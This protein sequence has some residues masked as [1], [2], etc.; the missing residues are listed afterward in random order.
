MDLKTKTL[1]ISNNMGYSLD[2]KIVV[3]G[4][5]GF[6]GTA[7]VGRLISM[8][9]TNIVSVSRNEGA[10][11]ALKEKFPSVTIQIGDIAD[12]WVVKKAMDGA[13]Q[14]YVL[15][16]LKHVGIAEKDVR[17]CVSTNIDGTMNILNESLITKP[18]FVVFV[19][20]DKAAQ[21][22]G[23]Y[24]AS[25][26]IGERLM[27]EAERMNTETQYRVVR[28]GNVFNSTGSI[29]TKWKPKMEK[30]EEVILTDPD[31][32]RF[33][34]T[35]DEAVDLIFDSVARATDAN[36]YI[37][38]IKAVTM[39]VVL[40]AM[41]DVYGKSPVKIIGLQPGENKVETMDGI[42]FSDKVEQFTKEE[43]KEKFLPQSIKLNFPAATPEQI[44]SRAEQIAKDNPLPAD[45]PLKNAVVMSSS[46]PA[47]PKISCIL[48]TKLS[49]YPTLVLERLDLDFFD[50][51]L[52]VPNCP[53]VYHRYKAA[54]VAKNEIIYVQDDDAMVNYQEL[55]KHYNGQITTA[56]P[57]D[58]QKKYEGSG[59]VLIGWGAFFPKSML[60]VFDDYIQK[61]GADDPHLLREADRIFTNRNQ[62][63]NI[64]TMPHEDLPQ[65]PDRMGYQKEHYT[66]AAEALAKVA[67]LT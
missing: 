29:S 16:A 1:T 49:E 44:R 10:A 55:F 39:G 21:G 38:K 7:L 4:G 17:S 12:L 64:V 30:G 40:E 5:S 57:L 18:Q 42:T 2:N 53:S 45:F 33:F 47:H 48:I 62:P 28:Y 36:P 8:G 24:G 15:S 14:L 6:L 20:S 52:I 60:G 22:T 65:T 25:K 11:V 63:W 34:W 9:H 41:M 58:F 35:V 61:Y 43:F 66:S 50:E 13:R 19:S 37:P 27:V 3:F 23:I 59:T 32:S 26:K 67:A 54:A 46:G 31:A 56:M 51:I